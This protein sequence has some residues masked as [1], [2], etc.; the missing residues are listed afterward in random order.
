MI[1]VSVRP[2][3]PIDH[4]DPHYSPG[5][6]ITYQEPALHPK[7]PHCPHYPPRAYTTHQEPILPTKSPDYPPRAHITHQEPT[8][9]TRSPHYP[10]GAH[11]RDTNRCCHR[12]TGLKEEY[13]EEDHKVEGRVVPARHKHIHERSLHMASNELLCVYIYIQG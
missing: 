10:P 9:P 11:A 8:L 2:F 12:H 1:N 3:N 13:E 4:H 5:A 6:H 7:S